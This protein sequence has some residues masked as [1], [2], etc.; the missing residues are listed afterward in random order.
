MNTKFKPLFVA[1]ATLSLSASAGLGQGT[2]GDDPHGDPY[3]P[4]GTLAVNPTFV[5]TGVKPN[6]DWEID[7]PSNFEDLTLITLPG[8]LLTT[9]EATVVVQCP[10]ASG[11]CERSDL[12]VAFWMRPG[13]AESWQLLFYGKGNEVNP[14]KVLFRRKLPPN[15]RIDFA[16]R[17]QH[18]SGAWHPIVWTVDDTPTTIKYF[19]NGDDSPMELADFVT[20]DVESFLTPY[21]TEDLTNIVLGPKEMVYL[22]ELESGT[23]GTDCYDHQDLAITVQFITKN[24]NGHGNNID[25]IDVS[26]PG[27]GK[28]GPNGEVDPSG[29]VD[30]EKPKP[31]K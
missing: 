1:A 5:Q 27:E 17:G 28:G 16:A 4:V 21:L 30:D 13:V 22:Y 26:N 10:G 9:E 15:T 31:V 8:A 23:P 29:D 7:Y 18:S 14:S 20:G 12:P 24:N 3:T 25:G 19:A 2:P 6:L 11:G